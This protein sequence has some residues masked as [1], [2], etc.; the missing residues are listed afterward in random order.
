MKTLLAIIVLLLIGAAAYWYLSE[1]RNRSDV[2]KA[3][4]EITS[5]AERMKDAIKDKMPEIRTEDIKEELAK[6]GKVVRQKAKE[7][8]TAIA[9]A[10]ADARITGAIKAKLVADPDLSA[11]KISVNTTDGVVT[12]SG[13]VTSEEKIAKAMN[14]ALSV[15]G[16]R[17]AISTLQI[18]P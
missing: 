1:G 3:Q 8:G 5:G 18:K 7:A 12:L 16:V 10:T 2:Q 4:E 17:E 13:S 6:T 9:D 14:L 11:L 15:D